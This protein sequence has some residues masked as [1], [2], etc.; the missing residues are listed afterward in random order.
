M[1]TNRLCA[2]DREAEAARKRQR[3]LFGSM[4]AL[5]VPF[6]AVGLD[7]PCSATP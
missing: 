3:W 7:M 6:V 4:V 5:A 2:E 1:R